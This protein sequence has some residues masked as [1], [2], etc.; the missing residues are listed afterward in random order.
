MVNRSNLSDKLVAARPVVGLLPAAGQ[1]RRMSGLPFSKE[2]YPVDASDNPGEQKPKPVIEFQIENMRASGI[3]RAF[4]ILRDGKWDIPGHLGDGTRFDMNLGYL[5]MNLPY[6]VPYTLDQAYEFTRDCNV[7]L[8]FPDIVMFPPDAFRTC[9]LTLEKTGADVVLGAFPAD[10]PQGADMVAM[11][12]D[13][14]LKE[15]VVKPAS[16]SLSCAWAIATWAPA[17]SNFLH[18]FLMETPEPATRERELQVADVLTTANCSGFDIRVE[19]VSDVPFI[20]VG[21]P[22]GLARYARNRNRLLSPPPSTADQES[23]S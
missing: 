2:L 15:L 6:G 4:V 7:A 9:L 1:A 16:S 10:C 23:T 14:R 19:V 17:F 11:T 21:T 20:D 13:G 22:H 18:N 12:P 5:M 8:G 3:E